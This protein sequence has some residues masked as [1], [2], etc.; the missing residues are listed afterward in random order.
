MKDYSEIISK[1]SLEEKAQMLTGAGSM[2]TKAFE[3]YGI[4]AVTMADGPAGVRKPWDDTMPGGDVAFPTA[5]SLAMTWNRELVYEVGT[6]LAENCIAHDVDMLLAPATNLYRNPLCGRN[7]EYFSEDP[8]LAGELTAEYINGIQSEGVG[9]S[10]KHF[11]ANSQERARGVI[12]S[13]MDERTLRELYLR[14]FE[15][16]IRKSNPTSVMCAYN[17][18]NGNYCSENKKLLTDILRKEWG[19]DGMVVSDWGAVHHEGRAIKAGLDL[20]MPS[21]SSMYE[22]V[23]KAYEEGH[24]SMEEIDEAVNRMI[25]FAVRIDEMRKLRKNEEYDRDRLHAVAKK[26]ADEAIVLL[27]NE[28]NI[29]PIKPGKYKKLAVFGYY[30]EKPQCL[31]G[32]NGASGGVTVHD[33][34]IDSALKYI[35]EYAGDTEI[36]YEP[37]YNELGG[38]PDFP[39]MIRMQQILKEA[40]AAIMFGGYPQY[41]EVEGEDR[42]SLHL[43]HYM[44]RM[45]NE[46]AR[47]CKNTIVVLQSGSATAPYMDGANPKA[48]VQMGYSGEAAG[49]SI[50]DVL[51]GKVNPSGK[52]QCTY[53]T[54]FDPM[55]DLT[56]DGRKLVY[57]EG[58]FIGYRYYDKH[59]E[60]VWYPFGYGLSYTTFEYGNLEVEKLTE[61]PDISVRVRFTVKNTGDVYGAEAAQI[62]VSEREPSISRPY[63]ELKGFEKV[64]LAP[65][66]EKTVEVILD[67]DAFAYYNTNKNDWHVESGIYDIMVGKSAADICLSEAIDVEWD[68]D[69]TIHRDRWNNIIMRTEFVGGEV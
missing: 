61:A 33:E 31:G 64:F 6:A 14:H 17:K 62:Y 69:Y 55:L 65:G 10:L 50:A 21:D 67:K 16:I 23:K 9:T 8:Y 7:Y 63:K 52:L 27:K 20:K 32:G 42:F 24:V 38:S 11:C 44:E 41:Y 4:K 36:I 28:D 29:L 18:V 49:H 53:M 68:K 56:G 19:Y 37:I 57:R 58:L 12:N 2:E 60:K 46:T 66:E 34:S 13:E 26:A 39:N 15:T 35:K 5:S 48:I 54:A 3:K 59:P 30:A 25:N 43:P 45:L 22:K 47:F 51:F 40:D 1:M